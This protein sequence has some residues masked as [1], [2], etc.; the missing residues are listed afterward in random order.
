MGEDLLRYSIKI[1]S[2]DLR[3]C[4][5]LIDQQ[6]VR[7]RYHNKKTFMGVLP[8]KWRRKP[9]GIYCR[10]G[11]KLRHCHPMYSR[12]QTVYQSLFATYELNLTPAS[13]EHMYSSGSDCNA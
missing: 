5:S 13:H 7:K 4:P 6:S 1:E 9:V 12:M 11:T 3:Q 2:S 10:Y 8:I